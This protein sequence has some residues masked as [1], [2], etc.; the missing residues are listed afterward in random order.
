MEKGNLNDKFEK[1]GK[2]DLLVEK[3]E[4]A[5]KELMSIADNLVNEKDNSIVILLN[6]SGYILCKCGEKVEIK[7]GEL[8]RKIA[9]GGGKDKMAQGKCADDIETLKSKVV[10]EL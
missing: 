2:Y 4:G 8:L 5:P 1:V 7:M 3:V 9:K 6:N 10:G